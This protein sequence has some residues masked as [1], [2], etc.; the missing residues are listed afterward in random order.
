M[1]TS[2]LHRFQLIVGAWCSFRNF[3]LYY[4]MLCCCVLCMLS[5][6][7]TLELL[8]RDLKVKWKDTSSA[9]WPDGY[10]AGAAALQ[11]LHVGGSDVRKATGEAVSWELFLCQHTW[12]G[13]KRHSNAGFN[14]WDLTRPGFS[15]CGRKPEPRDTKTQ[16]PHWVWSW[17]NNH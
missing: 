6:Y 8:H 4:C 5:S 3:T 10:N 12:R 11:E 15:P 17:S 14:P 13:K 1:T 16:G 9:V 2:S 7:D